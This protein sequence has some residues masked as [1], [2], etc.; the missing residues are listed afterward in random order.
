MSL[1]SSATV[2][3]LVDSM[4][5][6]LSQAYQLAR[7]RLASAAS[8][9]LRLLV[10]RDQ[11][12]SETDLLRR[13]LEIFRVQREGLPPHQ[14]P[15]Y[16]P[17]QR[18]AI[19][20]LRRLRGWSIKKIAQRLVVHP[21]TIRSWVK[22]LEG[23]GRPSL[24]NGAV[25]WNRI[26]DAVRWAVHEL[27]RLCPEPE[28]GTRSIA[29]HVLRA[30]IQISRSTVQRVLREPKPPRPH[31]P[32]RPAMAA[33]LDK[34]PYHLLT[35]ERINR[36]WHIDL[37]SLQILWFRFTVAAILDGFSRRLLCLRVY[38]HTPRARDMVALVRRV[39]KEF[40]KPRFIITDHGSQFRRQFRSGMKKTGI[41]PVQA[42]VR[43]PYLNGKLERAFRTFRTWWRLV[44]TGLTQRGIQ[45]RLD[46][47][48]NWFNERRPHS[49]LHGLTPRESWEGHR[50]PA[51][52]PIRARDQL[53]PQI[54]I[55]RRYYCGDPR[56][57]IIDIS[58]RLAA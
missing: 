7:A 30:S 25:V 1:L 2:L 54:E 10:Q 16:R 55:R 5:I 18:L 41:T 12:I 11:A 20:Q 9:I 51:P 27:R 52:V 44:L 23:K 42:R 33:P 45:R 32:A 34:K 8:P 4:A 3:S 53:H 58:V 50:L 46:V 49:A 39:C 35:P 47:L 57:P 19:L 48:G 22:A 31:R 26:D 13:E 14:R 21:N 6:V 17:E 29:R 38:R 28:F 37:L 36:V 24:L 43:A 56:L 40:G 15:N